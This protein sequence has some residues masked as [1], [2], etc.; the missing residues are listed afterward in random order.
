MWAYL[1][2]MWVE[3]KFKWRLSSVHSLAIDAQEGN[4][5]QLKETPS[6]SWCS[7]TNAEKVGIWAPPGTE[8]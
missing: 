4:E 6:S 3:P 1:H 8:A 5:G 2:S 7:W